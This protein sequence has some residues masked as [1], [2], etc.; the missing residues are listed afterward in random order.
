MQ[1]PTL[2]GKFS[3]IFR[4][5]IMFDS[6]VTILWLLN[7]S[8]S[9]KRYYSTYLVARATTLVAVSSQCHGLRT[10]YIAQ[11]RHVTLY[12][13]LNQ[14]LQN[15]ARLVADDQFVIT[16]F[17]Y[18]IN[19][20]IPTER[21]FPHIPQFPY[22]MKPRVKL[23]DYCVLLLLCCSYS[24]RGMPDHIKA[25]TSHGSVSGVSMVHVLSSWNKIGNW[26]R[27]I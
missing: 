13:K 19:Q 8:L 1:G 26:W 18:A 23:L 6:L 17:L 27:I 24:H 12:S 4:V 16:T 21:T 7:R 22:Y 15:D 11:N 9:L 20:P 10:A 5:E 25:S 3:R 2:G 14:I